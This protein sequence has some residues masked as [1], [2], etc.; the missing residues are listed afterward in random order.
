ML[1]TIRKIYAKGHCT[2]RHTERLAKSRRVVATPVD[3]LD[4]TMPASE[5]NP[6]KG[7]ESSGKGR[8]IETA[9]K[10]IDDLGHAASVFIEDLEHDEAT[11]DDLL[12]LHQR[13]VATMLAIRDAATVSGVIDDEEVRHRASEAADPSNSTQFGT[14]I[15]ATT[16]T[17]TPPEMTR[18]ADGRGR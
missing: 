8:Y 17:N 1:F 10:N 6:A 3:V 9:A 14:L 12:Q 11:E 18:R 2:W 5:S 15:R 13:I 4:R 7:Q 16:T